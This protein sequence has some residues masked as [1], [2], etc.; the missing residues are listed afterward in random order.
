MCVENFNIVLEWLGRMKGGV[1]QCMF[2]LF[3]NFASCACACAP[4]PHILSYFITYLF[5]LS[6]DEVDEMVFSVV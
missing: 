1:V 6:F 4:N 2:I 5:E 3:S